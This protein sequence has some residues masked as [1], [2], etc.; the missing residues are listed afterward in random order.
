MES[1]CPPGQELGCTLA[2]AAVALTSTCQWRQA[3][4]SDGVDAMAGERGTHADGAGCAVGN[5]AD[6]RTRDDARGQV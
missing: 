3:R 5:D 6:L 2:A 4:A 1:S